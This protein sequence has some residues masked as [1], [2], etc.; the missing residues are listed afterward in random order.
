MEVTRTRVRG[1]GHQNIEARSEGQGPLNTGK[2]G[3]GHHHQNTE[4]N[5]EKKIDIETMINQDLETQRN[6]EIEEIGDRSLNKVA[7][8]KI[9]TVYGISYRNAEFQLTR[10]YL[11]TCKKSHRQTVMT[12]IR[13]HIMWHLTR[14][15]I[16]C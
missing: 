14:V 10:S 13:R 11:E 12:Q 4:T 7:N 5:I 8:I 3:E 6:I 16:G 2:G 9:T 1:P 15:Y